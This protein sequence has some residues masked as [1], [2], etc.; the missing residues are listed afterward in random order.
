MKNLSDMTK[1]ERSLLLFLETQLVDHAGRVNVDHIND[2][3]FRIAERWTEEGFI[4]FKRRPLKEIQKESK[5][6]AHLWTRTSRPTRVCRFSDEAW[7]LAH[8]ER[9][10]RAARCEYKSAAWAKEEIEEAAQ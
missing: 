10:A 2:N 9:K 1:E 5:K 3:D 7:R 8:E 6:I 4:T